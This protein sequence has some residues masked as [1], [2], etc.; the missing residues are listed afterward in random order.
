MNESVAALIEEAQAWQ[1]RVAE[2]GL[3]EAPPALLLVSRLTRALE[4]S[5]FENDLSMD[6]IARLRESLDAEP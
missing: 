6:E 5:E 3:Y 4:Q 2:V 1:D